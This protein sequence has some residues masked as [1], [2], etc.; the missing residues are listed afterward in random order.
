[1]INEK[2]L[3]KL[4]YYDILNA[5]SAHCISSLAQQKVKSLAPAGSYDD[6]VLLLNE[7]KQA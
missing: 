4:Q 1:M 7:T 6:A 5:V 3:N 2:T